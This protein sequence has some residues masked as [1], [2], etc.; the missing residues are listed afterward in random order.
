MPASYSH[1]YRSEPRPNST[2][3]RFPEYERA[4][5][6]A[7]SRPE[8]GFD[9][10]NDH[11]RLAPR[12]YSRVEQREVLQAGELDGPRPYARFDR[13]DPRRFSR[14]E[15]SE[16]DD[17][18]LYSRLG[19]REFDDRLYSRVD[20]SRAE[21]REIDDPRLHSHL[22]PRDVDPRPHSRLD[23]EPRPYSR[24]DPRELDHRPYSPADPRELADRLGRAL[25]DA[26]P[27]PRAERERPPP[28]PPH[29]REDYFP[30]TD[31]PA[32]PTRPAV[33]YDRPPPPLPA[34]RSRA[35]PFD[36]PSAHGAARLPIPQFQ[37]KGIAKDARNKKVPDALLQRETDP[38]R[39]STRQRQIDY[40][41][42]TI[43]YDVYVKEVP[44]DRRQRGQP[45]TPDIHQVCSKRSWDGQIRKWRREL[46][47]F[48][49]AAADGEI[50]L[51]LSEQLG[52][53]DG[54]TTPEM[55]SA[56]PSATSSDPAAAGT[57]MP[58]LEDS[59]FDWDDDEIED[60]VGPAS[61]DVDPAAAAVGTADVDQKGDW[62]VD[63]GFDF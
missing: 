34:G 40:G 31:F 28:R 36:R 60:A 6:R 56:D 12:P 20:Y 43:G 44:K 58:P 39:L 52:N 26:R 32:A 49:P 42:N 45:V 17:P 10:F 11:D 23:R 48:D 19:P 59:G 9:S 30:L 63:F 15:P 8:P 61:Y 4:S 18:R 13:D 54:Q 57:P 5:N 53:D 16:I 46:H 25:D 50:E 55:P 47:N 7:A 14:L 51:D 27:Y 33:R 62:P 35:P 21:P 38:H 22:E 24:L 2:R 41:R 3:S 37:H 29:A 1:S